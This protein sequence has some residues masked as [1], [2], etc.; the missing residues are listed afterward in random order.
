MV[1]NRWPV[2]ELIWRIRKVH[3]SKRSLN[4]EYDS[5]LLTS[6]V[7]L[8]CRFA[9]AIREVDTLAEHEPSWG[10]LKTRHAKPLSEGGNK[11]CLFTA[12]PKQKL[13]A[14]FFVELAIE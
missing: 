9:K 2:F 1:K 13:I 12:V 8:V 10:R 7:A 5:K 6:V 3:L 4:E 14:E 11:W